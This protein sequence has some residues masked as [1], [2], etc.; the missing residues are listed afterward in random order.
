LRHVSKLKSARADVKAP[1]LGGSMLG[2]GAAFLC[3]PIFE[4]QQT[5]AGLL[6][7]LGVWRGDKW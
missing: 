2:C 6:A 5:T 7:P 1:I 4:E 3:W